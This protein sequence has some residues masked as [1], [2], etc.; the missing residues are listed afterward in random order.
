M[1]RSFSVPWSAPG[2]LRRPLQRDRSQRFAGSASHHQALCRGIIFL[3]VAVLLM[4]SLALGAR[5]AGSDPVLGRF[6]PLDLSATNAGVAV[7]A[8]ATA[9]FTP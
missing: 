3:A 5:Y 2:E 9:V 7:P 4:T 6:P 1:P 8:F